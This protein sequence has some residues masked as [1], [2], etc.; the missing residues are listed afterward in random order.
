MPLPFARC[1]A[2]C[3]TF[4]GSVVKPSTATLLAAKTVSRMASGHCPE[5]YTHVAHAM[6]GGVL[7]C[8][9]S[10]G[11]QRTRCVTLTGT[12]GQGFAVLPPG[13]EI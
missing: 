6:G 4:L 12:Q 5:N 9:A 10:R 8:W 2:V 1:T 11:T 3:I 13:A 7:F